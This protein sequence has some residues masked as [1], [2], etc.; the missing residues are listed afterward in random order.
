MSK[1]P[2]ERDPP[3]KER[4]PDADGDSITLTR[5][6]T[7]VSSIPGN[8]M[9]W[10]TDSSVRSHLQHAQLSSLKLSLKC[11]RRL[12]QYFFRN[13]FHLRGSGAE[14]RGQQEESP[15]CACVRACACVRTYMLHKV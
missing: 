10:D 6:D 1:V 15:M 9:E 2:E 3:K 12:L 8:G 4:R 13:C 7:H 11:R 5:V 14:V